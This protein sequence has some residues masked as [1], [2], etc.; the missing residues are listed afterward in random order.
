LTTSGVLVGGDDI[1]SALMRNKV[2]RF[3]GLGMSIN[4]HGAPL[5]YE[6]ASLLEHW[7]TIPIL[8]RPQNLAVISNAKENS[9]H[10]E[11]F[12]R[13][14]ALVLKNYGFALFQAI[15]EAKRALS[16]AESTEINFSFDG[17][18]LQLP[19]TREEFPRLITR[20]M[21]KVQRGLNK[22]LQQAELDADKIDVVV[23]T[24]GSSLIPIF[25]TM[26]QRKF[27]NA[28]LVRSDTFGSVTAGL[29]L[30]AAG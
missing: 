18:E 1:D 16:V 25:Q 9:T 19:L 27:S 4:G 22:M 17:W 23:T 10:G 26:L 24:G 21:A 2:G 5:P 8:S 20:E 11:A 6:L 13:L 7:Q 28:Q 30:K 14:E 29:A 3:F 15:E 12:E